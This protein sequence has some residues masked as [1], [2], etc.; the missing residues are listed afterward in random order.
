VSPDP[1]EGILLHGPYTV[2]EQGRHPAELPIGTIGTDGALEGLH[3]WLDSC[4]SP[5]P[6][7]SDQP[8]LHPEFPGFSAASPF[9]SA[10]V[11]DPRWDGRF[12]TREIESITDEDDPRARFNHAV[13]LVTDKIQHLADRDDPPRVILVAL[14]P[15]IIKNCWSVRGLGGPAGDAMSALDKRILRKRRSKDVERRQMLLFDQLDK[16][17][18]AMKEE[19]VYRN[20]RRAVK[21]RAMQWNVP[22]QLIQPG[23]YDGQTTRQPPCTVAWNFFVALYYKAGGF[24]WVLERFNAG[25]CFAGVSFHRH[26]SDS[27][28]G[29]YSSLAQVFSNRSDG[30]V[31]RGDRFEWNDKELGRSPHLSAEHAEKLAQ[32]VVKLYEAEHNRRP[33]RVVF[34][35]SSDYWPEELAG[36]KRGL[37]DVA[38][39]DL[40]SLSQRATRLFRE[41]D[42]PPVRGTHACIAG[43]MH[44][45]YTMG[46]IP[47]LRG[48]P[49]G[50]VPDPICVTDHHGQ[51][52]P[53]RICRELMALSKMNWNCADF[54]TS[55][56][57]T[58][59]FS[60]QV[61]DIMSELQEGQV[62]RGS[63]KFYM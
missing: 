49:R 11:R 32:K 57:I 26:V 53:E 10:L 14:P 51:S 47:F 29:V 28:V 12:S 19:L 9:R 3:R 45:L 56:P 15:E 42:Y 43:K 30:V 41:G 58:L 39:Y 61:G 35:K 36:F 21:A 37:A 18:P 13:K 7:K 23:I 46:Y 50:Y 22:I 27:R 52:S 38:D 5:I 44:I 54:A 48:Y 63:F 8:L 4:G 6:G 25:E 31:L 20:F 17:E 59:R 2:A 1:K 55:Q 62:P 40:V 60:R 33:S 34:H 16:L 24:P